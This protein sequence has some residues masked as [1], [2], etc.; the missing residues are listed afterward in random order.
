MP[1]ILLDGHIP[2]ARL[3]ATIPWPLFSG[4]R[5]N[6]LLPKTAVYLKSRLNDYLRVGSLRII[7][8]RLR[9]LM[10]G[11]GAKVEYV[12]V[13]IVHEGREYDDYSYLNFLEVIDCVDRARSII[14]PGIWAEGNIRRLVLDEQKIGASALFVIEDTV[15]IGVSDALSATI[16]KADCTGVVLKRPEDWRNPILGFK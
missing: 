10:E 11:A 13:S 15:L 8:P 6:R 4:Q 12:N 9:S 5:I 16:R 7:S 1:R 2:D 3:S 14:E